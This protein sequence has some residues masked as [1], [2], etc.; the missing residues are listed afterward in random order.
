MYHRLGRRVER[1]RLPRLHGPVRVC[2]LATREREFIIDN[3]LVRIPST[4]D[5]I[6]NFLFHVAL[7]LPSKRLPRLHG[8]VRVS[9]CSLLL[10][11]LESSDAQFHEPQHRA[12]LG[13]A[14]HFCHAIALKSTDRCVFVSLQLENMQLGI[15]K[16]LLL[17]GVCRYRPI[18]TDQCVYVSLER[19]NRV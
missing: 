3:L 18:F 17:S 16:W 8:P 13:T 10:S 15:S 7:Y 14:L 1:E 12:L 19:D 4:I 6:S 5:M 9:S 11:S 2:V